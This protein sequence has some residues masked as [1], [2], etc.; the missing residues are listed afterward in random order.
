MRDDFDSVL[1]GSQWALD[2]V[3]AAAVS[4]QREAV[5]ARCDAQ[6]RQWQHAVNIARRMPKGAD[7]DARVAE[8]EARP[9][10]ACAELRDAMG[11]ERPFQAAFRPPPPPSGGTAWPPLPAQAAAAAAAAA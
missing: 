2:A 6:R 1:G 9:T 7:R 4:L 11:E 5:R 10:A 8:A 3:D